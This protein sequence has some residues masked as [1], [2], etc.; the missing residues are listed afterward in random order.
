[1]QKG[2]RLGLRAV[3]LAYKDTFTRRPV[4]IIAPSENFLKEYGFT[5]S[6]ELQQAKWVRRAF[7][8][9]EKGQGGNPP[10]PLKKD[11]V[12]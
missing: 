2:Y 5:L 7:A 1:V 12:N 11:S 9:K 3:R 4:N 10:L 6:K 8:P